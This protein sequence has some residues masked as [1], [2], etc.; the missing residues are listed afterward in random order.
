M[1]A[2]LNRLHAAH[3]ADSIGT[4]KNDASINQSLSTGWR[5]DYLQGMRTPRGGDFTVSIRWT[6][7]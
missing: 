6:T 7:Y 2:M 5:H 3:S 4:I 1:V